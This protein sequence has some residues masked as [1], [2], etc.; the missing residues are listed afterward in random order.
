MESLLYADTPTTR[1]KR[2]PRG[3]PLAAFSSGA[4]TMG[5]SLLA[6]EIED[7]NERDRQIRS[8]ITGGKDFPIS[9]ESMLTTSL[10]NEDQGSL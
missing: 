9:F 6:V 1:A 7:C 2:S 4:H 10:Y 8:A 3:D 5:P